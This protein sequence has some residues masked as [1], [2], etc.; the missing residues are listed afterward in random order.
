MLARE[1]RK[2]CLDASNIRET[3]D[4]GELVRDLSALLLDLGLGLVELLLGGTGLECD[5]L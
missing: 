4:Q 5:L 2:E 3:L 1:K